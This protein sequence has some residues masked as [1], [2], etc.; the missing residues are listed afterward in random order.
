VHFNVTD[1]RAISM[2]CRAR[3]VRAAVELSSDAHEALLFSGCER[4]GGAGNLSK[5]SPCDLVINARTLWHQIRTSRSSSGSLTIFAAILRASSLLSNLAADRRPDSKQ[6]HVAHAS[7]SRD[8]IGRASIDREA[9]L[10]EQS[11]EKV[12]LGADI[13]PYGILRKGTKL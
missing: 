12:C 5:V 1:V 2:M 13:A 6:A 9:L 7:R 8:C 11:N 10:R 3:I 4:A